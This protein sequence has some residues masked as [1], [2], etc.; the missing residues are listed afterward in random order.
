[1]RHVQPL[2]TSPRLILYITIT[3]IH[4]NLDV[5]YCGHAHFMVG[6]QRKHLDM[7]S[8][9][10]Y[11][12]MKNSWASIKSNAVPRQGQKPLQKISRSLESP[13]NLNEN[14]EDTDIIRWSNYRHWRDNGEKKWQDQSSSEIQRTKF[15]MVLACTMR[16]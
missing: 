3:C 7:D 8:E 16:M 6:C 14:L 12:V 13:S 2:Y 10:K 4:Y 11:H 9:W 1:M 15:P 5:I